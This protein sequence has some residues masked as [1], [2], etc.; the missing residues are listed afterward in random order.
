MFDFFPKNSHLNIMKNFFNFWT[1]E[2]NNSSKEEEIRRNDIFQR[3]NLTLELAIFVDKSLHQTLKSTFPEN[4]DNHIISVITAMMNAVQ[5]LFNDDS[6]GTVFEN[7][8]NCLES[9][10]AKIIFFFAKVQKIYEFSREK[11]Q[12]YKK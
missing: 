12:K 4:T 5:I 2:K 3:K 6:L 10:I 1:N 8:Q 9:K 11:W 7:N